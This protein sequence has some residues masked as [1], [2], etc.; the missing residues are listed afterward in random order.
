MSLDHVEGK[1]ELG[2]CSDLSDALEPISISPGRWRALW[3]AVA[4][5]VCSIGTL[6]SGCRGEEGAESGGRCTEPLM[7][8]PLLLVIPL[9][10]LL[11]RVTSL[12]I[13]SILDASG[14]ES[15]LIK[16]YSILQSTSSP[17]QVR[18]FSLVMDSSIA[19][20]WNTTLSRVFP[21]IPHEM[22]LW[23][24]VKPT[25][26]PNLTQRNF[27]RDHIYAR[28]YLPRLF[29]VGRLIYLDNDIV[30]N[31]DLMELF[32]NPLQ[33]DIFA[34]I[35]PKRYHHKVK[36]LKLLLRSLM[37]PTPQSQAV[38]MV[39]ESHPKYIEYLRGHF[40]NASAVFKRTQNAI[41]G[42]NRELPRAIKLM[43]G[44]MEIFLNAGVIV[45]DTVRWTRQQLTEK[46]EAIFR[47]NIGGA[48]F[49]S[50]AVGDQ[51]VF[52][53][54]LGTEAYG[55]HPRWNMRRAPKQTTALLSDGKTTGIIHLAGTTHGDAGHLCDHPLLYPKFL[56]AV[57][58]LYLAIIRSFHEV[59]PT[60]QLHSLKSCSDAVKQLK[61]A[62]SAN[63]LRIN[64]NPGKGAFSF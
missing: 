22:K 40:N 64:Y 24:D 39:Y 48:L 27:D 8:S 11:P 36:Y 15:C 61:K 25:N 9:L 1:C 13:V 41:H 20:S 6:F 10:P 52:Y 31:A 21:L 54:L 50:K 37:F 26:F 45:M 29:P 56:P 4:R 23:E 62:Q 42:I 30:V 32:Q 35:I 7:L 5:F 44:K 14:T 55:L 47:L 17:L 28:F 34:N 43:F 59:H 51:G 63:A 58:P 2:G 19:E 38:G 16:L 49:D 3:G 60:E 33:G 57:L 18:L 53:L 12:H 46:A